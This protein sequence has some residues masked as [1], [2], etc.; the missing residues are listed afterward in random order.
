[1]Q[2]PTWKFLPPRWNKTFRN[3]QADTD[4]LLNFGKKKVD[5]AT[6][7]IFDD[8]IQDSHEMSVLQKLILRNG[9]NS[10][11]P[12]VTA[13]DMIF[14]GI[15][16]TGNTLGFLMYHLATNPDKQEKLQKECQSLGE[17][18][19]VKS[20]NELRYLKACIQE[21]NRL[22]PTMALMVRVMPEEFN[23]HGYQIPKKTMMA[24]SPMLFQEQFKDWDKFIPE[25]WIDNRIELVK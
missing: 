16:T 22:T 12:L 20:L 11:Y 23:L 19:S 9:P 7:R 5:E 6:K 8:N 14:A 17:S 4:I 15:D 25:R 3:A 18:L 10:S 1:M 13:I 24:W 21:S 2:W